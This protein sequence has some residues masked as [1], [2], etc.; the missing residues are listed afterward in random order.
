MKR[1]VLLALFTSVTSALLLGESALATT[2][3]RLT[4]SGAAFVCANQSVTGACP[5]AEFDPSV[6]SILNAQGT[7]AANVYLPQGA[8][9]TALVLCGNFNEEGSSITATLE[10]T[11]LT[12]TSSFPTA[13]AMATVESTGAASDTRCFR[14][15]SITDKV[16]ANNVAQYY[17][18]VAV[19][20]NDG[21]NFTSVQI[22]YTPAS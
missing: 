4:L 16:I 3:V 7:W 5:N 15:A 2:P 18:V 13:V 17:V 14:T 19:P 11:P 8:T 9:I 1:R 6:G 10:R 12:S 20:D 22:V 21:V